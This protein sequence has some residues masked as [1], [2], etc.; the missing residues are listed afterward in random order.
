MR[1]MTGY[2][3]LSYQDDKY[4]LNMELKS[5]N[6][7][8]L[9]LK[10]KLP[11]NLNFLEGAIRTEIASKVS[12][13]S[14]DLKIE[15]SDLRDLGK[16]FD[17]D[18]EQSKG[19]MNVLLEMEKDFNEKFSNKMDILVRNLNV[20]K[21]NDFE[22]DEEEYTNFIL[23]KIKELLTPFIKTREEEG[24]R[25]RIYFL[26]RISVL[27]A[28]IDEI[29]KYKDQVVE[30]YKNKLLERLD[31]IKGNIEFKE[32]DIL[33]EILLFT[34]KSDISEEISRLDSH[35]EQLKKELS[36]KGVAVGKKIDFILQEIYRELNT[37][38]VKSNLYEISKLIVECKNE[39]EK[40]RE[41]SM[42]IE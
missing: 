11:Y 6:N 4:A 7:K 3:K 23:G 8:N 18:K 36:L 19:Y 25:L 38:G 28:N 22:I 20:I 27:E 21:K 32:E 12:R 17:Y 40:I 37:T 31:K 10:I 2:S 35:M 29:K 13:G 14:L 33:K 9:N 1:S 24:E 42:N 16:L 5:V 41:Q 30:I 15:F 34:D 26:E 39:L